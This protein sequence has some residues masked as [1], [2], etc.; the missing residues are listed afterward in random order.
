MGPRWEAGRVERALE[1]PPSRST[2]PVCSTTTTS[3]TLTDC[4]AAADTDEDRADS[5]DLFQRNLQGLRPL[6][7]QAH[8]RHERLLEHLHATDALPAASC[9]PSGALDQWAACR[10]PGELLPL[11]AERMA[12]Y[13]RP[14]LGVTP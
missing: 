6:L 1:N 10:K 4:L 13:G 11:Q 7:L 8:G 3:G 12:V 5:E 14:T 2:S 9:P